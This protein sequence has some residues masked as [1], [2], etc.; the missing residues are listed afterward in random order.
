MSDKEEIAQL[1][2]EIAGRS[3]PVHVAIV[4]D[5]NGRWAES[6]NLPRLAGHRVGSESV[7]AVTR[8]ARR[9]GVKALTLYAFSAQN[10]GRP[11]DEVAGLMDLLREYLLGERAELLDNQIRLEAIGDLKRLP[12]YVREPLDELCAATAH[13]GQMVL[14]LALSYGSREELARVARELCEEVVA[15]RLA[16]TDIGPNT[17]QARLATRGLPDPDL[18][19]RTGGEWRLSN[20]L[21]WQAAYTELMF[22]DVP[23]P[24]FREVHFLTALVDYQRRERRFGLTSAQLRTTD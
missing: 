18:M 19:L 24:D 3:P 2:A 22:V 17:M 5:G 4:M 9:V 21:L 12:P 20:F 15:G 10:W 1:R 14:T 11:P 7:R 6:R 16:V 8:E 23:W 13:H